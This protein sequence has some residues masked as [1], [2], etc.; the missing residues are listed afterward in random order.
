MKVRAKNKSEKEY[1]QLQLN[2]ARYD[3]AEQATNF[4]SEFSECDG[5]VFYST[6]QDFANKAWQYDHEKSL[7]AMGRVGPDWD[8]KKNI[9]GVMRY[10]G[11]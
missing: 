4:A 5:D 11:I 1:D 10:R 9:C 7:S 6:Y 3:L 2:K 8:Y